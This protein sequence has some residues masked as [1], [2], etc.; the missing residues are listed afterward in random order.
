MTADL[1]QGVDRKELVA[2]DVDNNG[3]A[4]SVGVRVRPEV[5]DSGPIADVTL[6]QASGAQYTADGL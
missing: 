1:S 3:T 2:R 6:F 5:G 4:F